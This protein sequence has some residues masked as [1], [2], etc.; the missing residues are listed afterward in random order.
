[1]SIEPLYSF[2][3]A[4]VENYMPDSPGRQHTDKPGAR[5]LGRAHTPRSLLVPYG[6]PRTGDIPRIWCPQGT[7]TVWAM[8]KSAWLLWHQ[9]PHWEVEGT[10]GMRHGRLCVSPSSV[11]QPVSQGR[12]RCERHCASGM[13]VA[14]SFHFLITVG[15]CNYIC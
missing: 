4:E 14:S 10:G 3:E 15:V 5:P 9:L 12:R 13:Q 7:A 8:R 2:K 11:L 6:F 1:M